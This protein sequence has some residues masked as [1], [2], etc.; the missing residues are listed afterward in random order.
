MSNASHDTVTYR[1]WIPCRERMPDLEGVYDTLVAP[2]LEDGV[3]EQ[4]QRYTRHA[5][6]AIN[7][8]QYGRTT[9]WKPHGR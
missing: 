9:H 4:R 2:L 5:H 1:E 6:P 8:W 3:V 7:P